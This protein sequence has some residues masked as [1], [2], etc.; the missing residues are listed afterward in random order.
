MEERGVSVAEDLDK[1]SEGIVRHLG[2]LL[3]KVPRN[4]FFTL[5][6]VTP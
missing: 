1:V 5:L 4:K 2:S 3:K 6:G